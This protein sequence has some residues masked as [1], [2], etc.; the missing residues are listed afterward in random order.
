ARAVGVSNFTVAVLDEA[1]G[2]GVELAVHQFEY[3]PYVD[4][5]KILEATR[6][7]G[8]AI[9]AY[10]PMAQGQVV[11]DP[12]IED[13]GAAHGKTAAQVAL[14]WLIQQDDVVVIPRTAKF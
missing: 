3:H 4:Q 11:G 1:M 5:R 12:V 6:R 14:R 2:A 8:L 9:T 13:I 10:S 7:H